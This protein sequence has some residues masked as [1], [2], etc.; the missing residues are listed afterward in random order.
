MLR[1]IR[2]SEISKQTGRIKKTAFIPRR[3]GKDD[4]GLSVSQANGENHEQLTT[5]MGNQDGVFCSLLAGAIRD[6]EEQNV[7]LEVYLKPTERDRLHS[8]IHGVPTDRESTALATR[9]AQRLADISRPYTA[10][11]NP[12]SDL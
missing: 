6:I 10:K 7:R 5:R 11:A 2:E 9:L 8:L 12:P 3:N 1:G 4:D